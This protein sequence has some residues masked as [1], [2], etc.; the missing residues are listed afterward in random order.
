MEEILGPHRPA[1]LRLAR[2]YGARRLRVFGSVRRREATRTSDI[3]LIVEW[4]RKVS[5]LEFVGM[6]L[7]LEKLLQ[8]KVDLVE[9][10]GLHWFIRPQT[11]AEAVPL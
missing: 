6:R 7:D 1:I 2:K 11:V 10:E 4:E 9:E 3:D 5:T 8:R